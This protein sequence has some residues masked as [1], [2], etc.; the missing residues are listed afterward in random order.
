MVLSDAARVTRSR[1]APS[2]LMLPATT[3]SPGPRVTGML[4][5]VTGLSSRADR[6][7]VMRPS[8]GTRS[9]GRTS[10]WSPMDSASAGT[11]S[12]VPSGRM[13]WATRGDQRSQ[14]ADAVAGAAGGDA[15]QHLAEREQQYDDRRFLC[16]ADDDG[17]Q[18]GGDHERL[19]AEGTA[20]A[21]EAKARR[22]KGTSAT[23]AAATKSG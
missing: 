2:A 23:I 3:G 16:R 1:I 20:G 8:Q 17:T 5:P 10:T 4:S 19:D 6:P 14:R 18:G 12:V 22:P 15:F 13:R 9:P 21:G 7:S 11:C